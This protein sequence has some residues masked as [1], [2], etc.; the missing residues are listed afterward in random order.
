MPSVMLPL[1]SSRSERNE[2]FSIA[3][4]NAAVKISVT[5]KIRLLNFL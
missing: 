4:E 5:I 2:N 1:L 3:E